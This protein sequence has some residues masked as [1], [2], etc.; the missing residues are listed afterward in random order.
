MVVAVAEEITLINA[1]MKNWQQ[2]DFFRAED[3]FFIHLADLTR[4]LT[5]EAM[6]IARERIEAGET[7][8][9]EGVASAVVGYVVI[10]QT[11][12]IVRNCQVRSYIELSPLVVVEPSTLK[13]A[14]LLRRPALAFLP[15]AADSNM[16]ADLDRMIT[17][18]KSILS[19][20]TRIS[21]C[22][23]DSDR[24][25]FADALARHRNRP[26]FPDD[27]N[28]CMSPLRDHLKKIHRSSDAE[29]L[30]IN[31]IGEIRVTASP[32]WD[33]DQVR[34]FVW[35]IL[36][37]QAVPPYGDISQY[38]DKWLSLFEPSEKYSLEAVVCLL[39][40]MKASEYVGSDRLDL[41]QLSAS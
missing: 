13:E 29:G 22:K 10:T 30:L 39:D 4:P 6:D 17:I 11:C 24:R 32:C 1:A 31:S 19:S 21:G 40:E 2:G 27:F 7:L 34:I 20:Y 14:R 35:F 41:D 28:N 33:T 38:I 37:N 23:S 9:V 36:L 12:D 26:A 15:G 3:L 5:T 16:L 18:E 25:A 8:E